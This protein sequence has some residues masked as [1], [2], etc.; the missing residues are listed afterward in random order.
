[1][2]VTAPTIRRFVWD[3]TYACPLR[4]VHCYSESG[5]RAARMLDRDDGLRVFD[6]IISTKP[7]R[8]SISGGEPLLVPWLS[9]GLRRVRANGISVTVH[10]S[11]WLMDEALASGL[12]DSANVVVVSVDGATENTH[13]TVRGRS[14]SFTRAMDSI[15][16]L[17]RIKEER[18]ARNEVCYSLGLDFT[19]TR[20]AIAQPAAFVEE[21]TSR[22]PLLDYVRVGAAIPC[23]LAEEESFFS[24][25]L[26]E[27]ELDELIESAPQLKA[28]SRHG[29]KVDVA[30]GRFFRPDCPHITDGE[31]LAQLEPDGQLRALGPYEMKVGSVLETPID[32]LWSRAIAWR[33]DP[34]VAE[35]RNSIRSTEDWARVARVLDRRYGSKDDLIR[36]SRRAERSAAASQTL[37]SD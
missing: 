31:S 23:G 6:V 26:T 35:Q 37:E 34:F 7:E 10:T 17:S 22:F 16:C 21:M 18:K 19:V 33:N 36:L 4:C 30:D 27:S 9:E 11:G 15:A 2:Q 25:L 5:R 28:R 29:V 13:D 8:V 14:G 12:A 32:E 20:R 1:M 24:E 3:I